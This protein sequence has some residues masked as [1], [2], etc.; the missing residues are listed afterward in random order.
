GGLLLVV[1]AA[2]EMWRDSMVSPM[3]Y[4]ISP[5]YRGL[6]DL[7]R[8]R[9]SAK[10]TDRFQQALREVV[11]VIAGL[12]AVDGAAVMTDS[13]ELLAF[14]A[15]IARGSGAAQAAAVTVPRPV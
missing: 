8:E 4:A 2:S 5:A 10:K 12:T 7:R 6:S 13:Y 11:D 3:S 1:P 9:A 15:K 14:C